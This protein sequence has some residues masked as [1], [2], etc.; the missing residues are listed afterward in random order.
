MSRR[1]EI[2]DHTDDLIQKHGYKGFSYADLSKRL[3]IAKA[4]IHHHFAS[5]EELG[6]AY[7]EGK[8]EAMTNFT[9][10]LK[11][12]DS[13][14]KQ[15]ETYMNYVGTCE[16][17]MCGLN[18]MQSDIGDMSPELVSKV[19]ELSEL[20][21][22]MLTSILKKGTAD[23]IFSLNIKPQDQA[24]MISTSL[25]GALL[26]GCVRNDNSYKKMCNAIKKSIEFKN[27]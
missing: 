16:G 23:K 4:S 12:M 10:E 8:I 3:G 17:K 6:M 26:L 7:C 20:E 2:L 1:Q 24:M 9:N 11:S 14:K 22:S 27:T 5:K 13:A 19:R 15:L 25:K 21:L 18:A